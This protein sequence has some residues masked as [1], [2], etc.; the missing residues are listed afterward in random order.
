MPVT[1]LVARHY[2]GTAFLGLTLWDCWRRD[3][4]P[5]VVLGSN[6]SAAS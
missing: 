1:I 5:F 4:A 2:R 3:D 6:P